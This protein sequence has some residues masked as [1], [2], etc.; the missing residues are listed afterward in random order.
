[1]N[2]FELFGK[3]GINNKP[4]NK[5]IDETTG[6]AEGA[7]SKLSVIFGKIGNLAV[8]AGKVMA[9][10]LAVGITAI[11]S[12]TG[13]AVKNY[14]EYEQLVGGIETLFGAGGKSLEEYAKSVGK[15][16]DD[17]SAEYDK[18]INAQEDLLNKSKIAY[19]TA[20][21][22]ANEYM[23]TATSFSA[24][25]I[26]SVKGDT[27]K[28]AKLADQAII[29]MSDNANKMGS[30]MESIQNAYQGF[31]KQNYT[32]LDN[33]K[34]GFGGTKEE[35]QRLLDEAGKI[36]SVKYDISSFADITEAIH[37][38]Q[39][40]MG[41]A[42]TTSKE[43][44][45]TISG[46]LGMVKA[47]WENFLTGMSDPEQDFGEL[48][49]S[50]TESIGIALGNIIPKLVQALPRVIK[51][52]SRIIQILGN[53]LPDL[54]SALLP[55]LI[56]GATELLGELGSALPRLFL[57]LFNDIL[58]QLSQAFV[59]FLEKVFKL[60]EGS[61]KNLTEGLNLSFATIGSMFDVLFGSL[62]EKD[63]ID[64]LTKLGMDPNTAQMIITATTQIR[65][66]ISSALETA[67]NLASDGAG[68]IADFF[69][70][71]K[72]GG[73]AVDALKSAVVGV[74]GAWTGYK[75]ATSII[76]GIE[77]VRNVVLGVSNGLM[78]AR[79]VHTGALTTAEGAHAA[80]T[81]AGT[82]AMTTFNAVMAANPIMMI[83]LAI[84]ALVAGLIWFFTQTE[85]GQKIW[86]SFVEFLSNAWNF[87]VN[88][89]TKLWQDLADFFSLLWNSITTAAQYYWNSLIIFFTNIWSKIS[90]VGQFFFN[91]IYNSIST[92]W[93]SISSFVSDTLN[94]IFNTV[95][96]VFN[97]VWV[98][99]TNIWNGIKNSISDA[100]E[101][102][103]NIVS[104][105]IEKIKGLFNFEFKWP[106][107]KMP[108]FTFEGSMNP[109][110]WAEKG[111][112]SIGVD[113]YAKGGIMTG[114]TV[115]GMNG[116]NLMVGGEAGPEAV[117][118]LNKETMGMLASLIMDQITD[119]IVIEVPKQDSQPVYL[120]VDG[121]TIAKLI[122]GHISN[123][124]AQRMIIL[125]QGGAVGW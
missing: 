65:D 98:T 94:T 86:S 9:T 40:K 49:D 92:V 100:I 67:I 17:A 84:G 115:F 24:S 38:M 120:Q 28:A 47:S 91:M 102:A 31:A 45:S 1:M 110:E 119:K 50:L 81:V 72:K 79:A 52:L 96:S 20:G 15:S 71:F 83:V 107:L 6:K 58:P 89:G 113:W 124:Q 54:L 95:S 41:I 21:L 12:L 90:T 8:K 121:Q 29:D 76:T 106:H 53:Y 69:E 111:V 118:P 63:N 75:I 36:S 117:L 30:S 23:E 57:I 18:L 73:V 93:S 122:V 66:S 32:M 42:G 34:L 109:L 105:T 80:A 16:V 88:V 11:S 4:A 22:S 99:V 74:A 77:K 33:L 60:P 44:A 46:S 37:V 55:G 112:P 78:I 103:K 14:A 61:L 13:A 123:E 3:I 64:L 48:V 39:V 5:A 85:T 56:T 97:N 114:P 125:D 43:A 82:G 26:Q 101:G 68:K 10:G 7:H 25:L 70:W 59:T 87:V 116:N 19:K 2:V 51:G 62:N 27:E 104:N 108:H 35:M